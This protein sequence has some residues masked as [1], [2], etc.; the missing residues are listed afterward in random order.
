MKK[1]C[2]YVDPSLFYNTSALMMLLDQYYETE[3]ADSLAATPASKPDEEAIALGRKAFRPLYYT[4][5]YEEDKKKI[6]MS[7]DLTHYQPQFR[8]QKP[9]GPDMPQRDAE[10]T[11]KDGEAQRTV[12]PPSP[13]SSAGGEGTGDDS[14]QSKEPP[15]DSHVFQTIFL[16]RDS[17]SHLWTI[18]SISSS[19]RIHERWWKQQ[20]HR[21]QHYARVVPWMFTLNNLV[22]SKHTV[23]A[24]AWTLLNMHEIG[25]VSGF[26]AA[27]RLGA[28]FPYK[29]DE[30][31][32][33]LFK[34][35][36]AVAHG[37]RVRK[38]DRKGFFA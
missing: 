13:D 9:S 31:C 16:D 4:M 35:Y 36:Y 17:S 24:G 18:D 28:D 5:Q 21:W 37:G 34:L 23:Y 25:I 15:F 1:V 38:E 2:D 26:S 7:F 6:E 14:E 19:S 10:D 22:T 33:R 20:S 12:S 30:E 11:G 3:F 29:G 32:E 27:Y 8:G